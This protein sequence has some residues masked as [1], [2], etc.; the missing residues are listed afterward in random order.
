MNTLFAAR[1]SADS[2][3]KV[4]LKHRWWRGFEGGDVVV[5]VIALGLLNVVYELRD[6]AV[7]D[8]GM[9]MLLRL[10]RGEVD[11]GLGKNGQMRPGKEAK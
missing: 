11:I 6:K 10:L 3:W 9:R 8:K 4:G 7:E 5:F 2:L 1:A